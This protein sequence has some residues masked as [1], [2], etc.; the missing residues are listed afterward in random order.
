[1]T[2]SSGY[3]RIRADIVVQGHSSTRVVVPEYRIR[4]AI[5]QAPGRSKDFAKRSSVQVI[6]VVNK[7]IGS[8]E[9]IAACYL[10]SNDT[11]LIFEGKVAE[12]IKDTI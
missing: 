5:I 4:E 3:K 8:S 2:Q 12:F 1:M 6:E 7:A 9:V 10:P 11:I